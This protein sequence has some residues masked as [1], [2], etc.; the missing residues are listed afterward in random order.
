[1]TEKPPRVLI[2]GGTGVFG[3]KLVTGLLQHTKFDVVVGRRN[4]TRRGTDVATLNRGL[5][6]SR[7]GGQV[8][9][10]ALCDENS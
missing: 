6:P 7:V 9:W 10:F 3:G 5:G 2:V 4:E 8:S 1:M